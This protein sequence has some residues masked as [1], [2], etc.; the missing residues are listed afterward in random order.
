MNASPQWEHAADWLEAVDAL[1][2]GEREPLRTAIGSL[3]RILARRADQTA[4]V[5]RLSWSRL[6]GYGRCSTLAFQVLQTN[7]FTHTEPRDELSPTPSRRFLTFPEE[8]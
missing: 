1:A 5:G 6:R 2:E 7:G 8:N 3:A 4:S